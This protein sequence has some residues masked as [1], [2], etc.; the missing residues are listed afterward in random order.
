MRS[1]LQMA[2]I[3]SGVM[4][5]A[6]IS[7]LLA[8]K[9][10]T[11]DQIIASDPLESRRLYMQQTYSIR[12]TSHNTEAIQGAAI[13]VLSVKPQVLGSLMQ[14]LRGKIAL[15]T[16]IMSI[17]AGASITSLS[18]GLNHASIVRAMP[19]TPA[20]VGMGM[21]VWSASPEVTEVQH[22]YSKIILQALGEE[23]EVLHEYEIDR[24]TGISGAGPAF[25]FLL[26]EAII[27]AGV[28]MGFTRDQAQILTLQTI[29]GSVELMRRTNEHPTKLRNQVTSPGGAT[30]VGLYELEKGRIR[31]TICDAVFATFE[32]TQKLG[33]LS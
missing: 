31:T 18:Q 9:V 10:V 29:A 24:A 20:Q 22:S 26:I 17:V 15:D 12:T 14:T 7:G 28:Q 2:F 32:R 30:A 4:A 21:T 5:E 8:K 25:V 27:D 1:D 3:G 19:N 13:A 16:L 33:K 6:M 11:A 23:M